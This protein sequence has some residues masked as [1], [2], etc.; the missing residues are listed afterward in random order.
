MRPVRAAGKGIIDVYVVLLCD[1]DQS[2]VPALCAYLV[3][4][5]GHGRGLAHLLFPLL[6]HDSTNGYRAHRVPHQRRI[7]FLVLWLNSRLP[8]HSRG[9]RMLLL[10]DTPRTEYAIY[11]RFERIGCGICIIVLSRERHRMLILP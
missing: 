10:K 5:L 1:L 4:S 9:A 2:L 11:F 7:V 6:V 8:G 3:D